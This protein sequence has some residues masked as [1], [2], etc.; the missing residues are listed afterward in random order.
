MYHRN[1]AKAN[2]PRDSVHVHSGWC[3]LP[4][5]RLT[6][7]LWMMA[8]EQAYMYTHASHSLAAEPPLHYSHLIPNSPNKKKVLFYSFHPPRRCCRDCGLDLKTMCSLAR[9]WTLRPPVI[10]HRH[11]LSLVFLFEGFCS[12]SLA[13]DAREACFGPCVVAAAYA[14]V[15]CTCRRVLGGGRG[16]LWASPDCNFPQR[17]QPAWVPPRLLSPRQHI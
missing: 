17:P 2:V 10:R 12:G 8:S 11:L 16:L 14:A 6:C 5:S 15:I 9:T 7:T 3:C 13:P 1:E 4:V